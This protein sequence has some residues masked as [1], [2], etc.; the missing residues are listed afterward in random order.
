[1]FRRIASAILPQ[2]ARDFLASKIAR[3]L[4][5]QPASQ[6]WGEACRNEVS[7]KCRA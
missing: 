5:V 3:I 6:Q 4:S 2:V 7:R 1:M